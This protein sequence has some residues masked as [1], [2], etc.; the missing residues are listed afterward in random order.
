MTEPDHLLMAILRQA[1]SSLGD[2][3]AR[4]QHVGLNGMVVESGRAAQRVQE[5][6]DE[7]E[8]LARIDGQTA[9]MEDGK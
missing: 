6:M 4:A 2:A 7:I 9:R 1:K 8:R 5:M 3:Q